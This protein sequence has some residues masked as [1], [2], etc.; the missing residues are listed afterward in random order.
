MHVVERFT[1]VDP[2]TI[3]YEATIE[4]PKAYTR[5]W[6]IVFTVSRNKEPGFELMEHSC[7]EGERAAQRFL[8][9][10]SSAKET[11]QKTK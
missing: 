11:S 3:K 10:T 1:A 4:D 8:S 9:Y 2:D 5:P 7:H 6:K